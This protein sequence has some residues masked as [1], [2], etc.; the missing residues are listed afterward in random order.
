MNLETINP[1]VLKILIAARKEDSVI[2]ISKRI[3]LSFGWTYKW[4]KELIKEGILKEKWRGIILQEDNKSYKK[5]LNFIKEI[6]DIRF[7]Y[8]ALSLFGVRYC[9]TKTDAVYIWT[10]GRYNIARYREFYPIFIKIKKEDYPIL[11][12][13]CK[14]LNLKVKARKGVFYVPEVLK[15]FKCVKKNDLLV[16]PLDET[17]EFMEKNIY[18]FQPA[19][20]M[21][22]EMYGRRLGIKYKEAGLM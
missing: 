21:I 5:I 13:Y 2:G 7:Y 8:S 15:D 3:G 20:E 1:Y 9:F 22:Q 4:V 6:Q 14:K 10:E 12:Q 11:L 19:L 17:I 18:N 16:E